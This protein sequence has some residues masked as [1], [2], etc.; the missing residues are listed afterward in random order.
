[1]VVAKEVAVATATSVFAFE[2]F[3]FLLFH[4][5]DAD[6]QAIFPGIVQC[7]R[8]VA[9]LPLQKIHHQTFNKSENAVVL[10]IFHGAWKSESTH[11]LCWSSVHRDAAKSG[12]TD[13]FLS[14]GENGV[15]TAYSDFEPSKS[16]SLEYIYT[17]VLKKLF[18]LGHKTQFFW[19]EKS[20]NQLF[21]W[22]LEFLSQFIQI[23]KDLSRYKHLLLLKHI[24]TCFSSLSTWH[25]H[26]FKHT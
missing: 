1:M 9:T 20:L 17:R 21:L 5:T 11:I 18:F 26:P 13:H 23:S 4:Q 25:I 14:E 16:P 8:S 22:R 19:E 10:R 7:R 2:I 24:A 3:L 6:N 15:C 12:V